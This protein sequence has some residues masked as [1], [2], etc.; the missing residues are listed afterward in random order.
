M[1]RVQT[2]VLAGISVLAA[3]GGAQA[4]LLP[5]FTGTTPVG[6]NTS[7]NYS[8]VFATALSPGPVEQLDAG[9]FVTIYDI[10]GFVSAT[11]PAGFTVSTQNLGV[12]AQG[13]FPLDDP[14]VPNVTFSY[15]GP[16]IT[17]DTVFPGANIVSIFGPGG[18]DNWT[19]QTTRTSDGSTISHLGFVQ[20]P[21]IPE[22]SAI[23]FLS[24]LPLVLMRRR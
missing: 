6:P 13:T 24:A 23:I 2:G 3:A 20:V 4:S 7:F 14:V 15:T 19:S 5:A 11:A 16:P 12:T 17:A 8:L 21:A 1:K 9:D 10:P 22:P 18:I